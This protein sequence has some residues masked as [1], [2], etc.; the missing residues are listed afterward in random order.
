MERVFSGMRPTGRLHLGNYFGALENW[1]RLQDS[2]ECIYC[3]VDWHALSTDYE[4]PRQ[5]SE[6]VRSMLVDWLAAGIDPERSVVF[7]QSDV[8]EHAELHLLLSMIIP[9]SWVERIPTYK[10]QLK[11]I[12]GR[13]LATYGFLGYP[14][15]QTADIALYGA[16]KVPVGED[17]LPHIEFAREVVRRFNYLYGDV[18]VEPHPILNKTRRLPGTDGRKMSKSYDNYI[19]LS[20][21]D[22]QVLERVK[23]MITDPARIRKHD[24]GHPHVCNVFSFHQV[25]NEGATKELT[26]LCTEG[27]IGCVECKMNLYG[28]IRAFMEPMRERRAELERDVKLID[29]ILAS[30]SRRAKA[31][32]RETIEKVR[33][34]IGIKR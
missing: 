13:E 29:D 34:A 16:H 33:S 19:A 20:D 4:D 9:L 10:E 28:L 23:S 2:Y 24:P 30:G 14:V 21:P 32:A 3:I 1:V 8:L 25:F 11:E 6:N 7:V 31:Y 17:Q 22:E 5:L 15:L 18:L 27:R 12:Q 26:E